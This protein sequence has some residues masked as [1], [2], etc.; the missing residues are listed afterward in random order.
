MKKR[1]LTIALITSVIIIF[2]ACSK[3]SAECNENTCYTVKACIAADKKCENDLSFTVEKKER[4]KISVNNSS[5]CPAYYCQLKVLSNNALL[6]DT[7]F[8]QITA[9]EKIVEFSSGTQLSAEVL[10]VPGQTMI[11][12]VWLGEATVTICKEK[13]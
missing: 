1:Y 13:K 8:T 2:Q 9:F 6:L 5:L 4:Y 12:C 10:L 7:V 3:Q 11:N